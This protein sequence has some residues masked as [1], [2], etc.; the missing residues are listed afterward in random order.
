MFDGDPDRISFS[1][2]QFGGV[3]N[4]IGL[5][6]KSNAEDY[7]TYIATGF[8]RLGSKRVRI[9]YMGALTPQPFEVHEDLICD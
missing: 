1:T 2:V 9:H 3:A 8:F 6:E 4:E 7:R 5:P